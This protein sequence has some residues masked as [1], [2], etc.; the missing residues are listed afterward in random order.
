MGHPDSGRLELAAEAGL[1]V[2]GGRGVGSAVV[3]LGDGGDVELLVAMVVAGFA[4][5]GG[6][7][8]GSAETGLGDGGD[9]ELLVATIGVVEGLSVSTVKGATTLV[10][11]TSSGG[12]SAM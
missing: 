4:V 8:V 10:S 1:A 5:R 7:G 9:V 3:G 6:V 12:S 11:Y 2:G